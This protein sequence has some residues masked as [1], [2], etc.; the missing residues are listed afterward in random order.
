VHVYRYEHKKSGAGPYRCIPQYLIRK[1]SDAHNDDVHPSPWHHDEPFTKLEGGYKVRKKYVFGF[2]TYGDLLY[3]FKGWHTELRKR[4]F[5]IKRY[6]VRK[7]NVVVGKSGQCA[8]RKK[9]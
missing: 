1:M 9:P 6:N 4:G 3:W 8:F 5:V 7:K 2:A